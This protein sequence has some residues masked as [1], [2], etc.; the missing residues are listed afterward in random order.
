NVAQMNG[1]VAEAPAG[2]ESEL[3][4][5]APATWNGSFPSTKALPFSCQPAA[6][7]S[8]KPPG[9]RKY[10]A[11]SSQRLN[12][13]STSDE[14]ADAEPYEVAALAIVRAS[15]EHYGLSR[16]PRGR[17]DPA[18]SADRLQLRRLQRDDHGPLVPPGAHAGCGDRR[19]ESGG[20]HAVRS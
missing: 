1:D 19:V 7:A 8:N 3:E 11:G 14:H 2:I 20:R 12:G 9:T 5:F 15:H 17:G 13:S 6:P 16:R 10:L 18:R 4:S